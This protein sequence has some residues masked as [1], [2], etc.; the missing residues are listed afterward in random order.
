M[1]TSVHLALNT[2]WLRAQW[3]L[4]L[5]HHDRQTLLALRNQALAQLEASVELRFQAKSE[6]LQQWLLM[7]CSL[8]VPRRRF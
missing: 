4:A 5:Q 6:A 1:T 8:V 3:E 7:R 2:P